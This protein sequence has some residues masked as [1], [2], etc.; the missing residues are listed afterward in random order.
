MAIKFEETYNRTNTSFA[1]TVTAMNTNST[2][3]DKASHKTLYVNAEL[4][5]YKETDFNLSIVDNIFF[6]KYLR[7]LKGKRYTVEVTPGEMQSF[8]Y[9]PWHV[10]LKEFGTA[11]LW[12][13]ILLLNDC[14]YLKDFKDLKYYYTVSLDDIIECINEEY[15]SIRKVT[16]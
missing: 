4:S 14:V 11:D 2:N 1:Q 13:L 10:S 15:N 9:K 5:Q 6:N 16:S 3:I 8:M 12:Y 7:R